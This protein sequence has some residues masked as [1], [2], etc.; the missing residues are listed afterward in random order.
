MTYLV[1]E[2]LP[3]YLL[4]VQVILYSY[5]QSVK[6]HNAVTFQ[7]LCNKVIRGTKIFSD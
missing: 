2:A 5:F 7:M 4:R 1:I 6:L 3:K